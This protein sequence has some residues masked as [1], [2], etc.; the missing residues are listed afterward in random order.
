ML[1][2]HLDANVQNQSEGK[3]DPDNCDLVIQ[4]TL[5]VPNHSHFYGSHMA[6]VNPAGVD[7][8]VPVIQVFDDEAVV[9][10]YAHPAAS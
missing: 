9:D 10:V 8:C 3:S 6:A 5:V 2:L 1:F 7:C 4:R